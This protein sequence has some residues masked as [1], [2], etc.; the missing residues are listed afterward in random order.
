MSWTNSIHLI[1]GAFSVK[2]NIVFQTCSTP[3]AQPLKS[4]FPALKRSQL[5]FYYSLLCSEKARCWHDCPSESTSSP[6]LN[7]ERAEN[8]LSAQRSSERGHSSSTVGCTFRPPPCQWAPTLLKCPQARRRILQ[9]ACCAANPS[10][11]ERAMKRASCIYSATI[12]L[13]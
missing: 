8:Q 10:T 11:L 7:R 4:I 9:R 3:P 13:V 6:L 1:S 12:R 5:Y 2:T